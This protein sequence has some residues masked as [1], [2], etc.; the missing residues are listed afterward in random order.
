[1]VKSKERAKQESIEI[2]VTNSPQDGS[3]SCG[4]DGKDYQGNIIKAFNQERN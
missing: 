1:L 3:N 2:G 4:K